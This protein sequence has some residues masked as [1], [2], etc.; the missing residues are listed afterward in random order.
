[1]TATT[2]DGGIYA[3][4]TS[5][6]RRVLGYHRPIHLLVEGFYRLLVVHQCVA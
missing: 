5:H 6:R 4:A 1:M 3:T 2:I